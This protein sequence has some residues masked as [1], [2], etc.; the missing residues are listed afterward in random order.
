[1]RNIDVENHG[2]EQKRKE[3][4]GEG[5]TTYLIFYRYFFMHV[6]PLSC[7]FPSPLQLHQE[8]LDTF[9]VEPYT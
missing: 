8:I 4:D 3:D 6:A 9:S 2:I 5:E 1:M 7:S